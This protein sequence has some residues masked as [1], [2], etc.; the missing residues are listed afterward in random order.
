MD[1]LKK[2]WF[3]EI[4]TLWP[5]MCLSLEVEEILHSEKSKYQDIMVLKTKSHGRV[6][7][8]DGIIQCTEADEFSY[9]E[10]ISYLPLCSHPCPK[11]VLIIGG[12][13][14]GVARE[15]AKHPDVETIIQ[16][17]IDQR[18]VELSKEFLPFMA[19][20]FENPKLSLHIGDG[21]KFMGEHQR[22]FDVIITDSSDPVG[23][24]EALFEERYFHLMK[25]ALRDGGI[26]CSQAE[27]IW[28]G[29]G[30]D[31]A[32]RVYKYCQT[33]F[34]SAAY[35]Y[36]LVP[37]YPTGLIGF[38]L[39]SLDSKTNFKEPLRILSNEEQEQMKLRYYSPDIH[40]SAF[41]LPRFARKVME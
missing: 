20:G 38:V 10:M 15:V 3:S 11:K 4:C 24:A 34:S 5:G 30:L 25:N 26:I 29:S 37:T 2:G 19:T 39:G 22:E 14:G 12:G 7:T 18:V 13:D 21:F 41:V 33:L 17:E 28:G 36:C 31:I 8:L 9:Q 27:N 23:P 35:G 1:A 16:C 40:R 32:N 6:L